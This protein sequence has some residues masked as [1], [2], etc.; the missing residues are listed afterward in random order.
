MREFEQ[1]DPEKQER[2]FGLGQVLGSPS[3]THHGTL[4]GISRQNEY[5][6]TTEAA[7]HLRRSTSWLLRQKDI[8]YLPGRPNVYAIFDLD[9]WF[10]NNKQN[11][12]N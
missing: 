7:R 2:D 9:A 6:T 5:L 8:P 11:P 1:T 3:N 4:Q 12:L 10:E